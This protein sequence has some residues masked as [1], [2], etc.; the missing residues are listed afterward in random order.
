MTHLWKP[1]LACIVG[2]FAAIT[3]GVA[4]Y[5]TMSPKI[6]VSN[7]SEHAASEVTFN[8]PDNRVTFSALPPGSSA[9]I[10]FNRQHNG[11]SISYE[12]WLNEHRITGSRTYPID[13]QFGRTIHLHIDSSGK[14]KLD[15]DR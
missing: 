8:L 5:R 14:A 15:I 3:A 6:L 11:G 9:T 2:A 4:A 10:Y 1:V 12:L 13:H 7:Y